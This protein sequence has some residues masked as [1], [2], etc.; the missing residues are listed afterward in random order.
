MP[1]ELQNLNG[2][3][4]TEVQARL[5]RLTELVDGLGVGSSVR[6]GF[7]RDHVLRLHA[8]LGEAY[9]QRMDIVGRSLN[10]LIAS[11]GEVDSDIVGMTANTYGLS[12]QE[13]VFASGTLRV[14][15]SADQSVIIPSGTVFVTADGR[16]YATSQ[17]FIGRTLAAEIQTNTDRQLLKNVTGN[18]E[19]HVEATSTIAG[20]TGNLLAGT[21]LFL[22]SISISSL[23]AITVSTDFTGGRLEETD[24][25]LI[26]RVRSQ[27]PAKTLSTRASIAATLSQVS[28]LPE[29]LAVSSIGYGDAEMV[30]SRQRGA[31]GRGVDTYIRTQ[32]LPETA[33][34]LLEAEVT[35]IDERGRA[36]WS[37]AIGRDVAP[38]F[39][40]VLSVRAAELGDFQELAVTR[41]MDTSPIEGEL[42][43]WITDVVDAA[44][45]RY[46]TA[47]VVGVTP[48]EGRVVGDK[49]NVDVT[50]SYMPGV[51]TAQATVNSRRYRF[52][53][54]DTL[55]RAAI[56]T[57]VSVGIDVHAKPSA[58]LPDPQP[59]KD[60]VAAMFNEAGFAG[61]L[62][63]SR[64]ASTIHQF[65][66][67]GADVG[68]LSFV[69]ET[70]LPNG[71]IKRVRTKDHIDV[72]SLPNIAVSS[73]TS[74]FL[75]DPASISIA[76]YAET[77]PELI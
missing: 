27:L 2:L 23:V 47:T 36:V 5:L 14:E 50:L 22:S 28:V 75:C 65:L 7:I 20:L 58:A 52:V 46:Q 76:A 43:P 16:T 29:L 24:T 34:F 12:R 54:G 57:Y 38:G 9:S 70:L 1:I 13:A 15:V 74:I 61:R 56:P 67:A 19:F 48:N 68:A 71:E 51:A 77:L 32:P 66:P 62:H 6:R 73:R 10:P 42:S 60:A 33:Q 30:R 35:D 11:S 63:G 4:E 55:V 31:D 72:P 37:V 18:Y 44:F 45:S 8:I 59:I 39:Y 64:V 25:Q 69:L 26:A 40:R 41:G 49:L 21:P 17:A 53:G 3:S